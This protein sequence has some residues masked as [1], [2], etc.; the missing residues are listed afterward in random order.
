MVKKYSARGDRL[1]D[2]FF[3]ANSAVFPTARSSTCSRGSLPNGIVDLFPHPRGNS[4]SRA[5]PHHRRQGRLCELSRRLPAPR[6]DRTRA[7]PWSKRSRRW[8]QRSSTRRC[9]TVSGRREGRRHIKFVTSVA[10]AAGRHSRFPGPRSKPARRSPGKT[11]AASCAAIS[12]VA[13]LLLDRDPNGRQQVDS[14]TKM[15]PPRPQTV[16]RIIAKG[17]PQGRSNKNLS[18]PG[19]AHRRAVGAPQLHQLRFAADRRSLG[20]TRCHN[21]SKNQSAVSST[22]RHRQDTEEMLSLHAGAPYPGGTR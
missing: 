5:H 18:G 17:S 2:N 22:R 3:A 4:G 8:T 19:S 12:R 6:R 7:E 9:R 13:S 10:T 14:G 20:L 15:I 21:R 1:S 11:R 16:S